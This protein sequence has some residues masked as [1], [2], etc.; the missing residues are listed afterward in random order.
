MANLPGPWLI[1]IG[2]DIQDRDAD[3]KAF[4]EKFKLSFPNGPDLQGKLSIGYGVYGVPET[5]FIGKD[6]TIHYKHVGALDERILKAKVEEM[7]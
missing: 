4:I 5:F 2:V 3:A 6:G 7:L 1:V